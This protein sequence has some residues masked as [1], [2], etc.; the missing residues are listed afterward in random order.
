MPAW[1]TLLVH[2]FLDKNLRNFNSI[3]GELTTSSVPPTIKS[4]IPSGIN[5][6]N[7]QQDRRWM[8]FNLGETLSQVIGVQIKCGLRMPHKNVHL[9][10]DMINLG[11][12]KV[13]MV[14]HSHN[15]GKSLEV[16]LG[17]HLATIVNYPSNDVD[18]YDLEI[19][20]LPN[21]QLRVFVNGE[22]QLFR[23]DFA[24]NMKILVQTINIGIDEEQEQGLPFDYFI[25]YLNV[26]ILKEFDAIAQVLDFL[27]LP[28]C[29]PTIPPQCLK[30]ML[31]RHAKIN[32]MIRDFMQQFSKKHTSNW[33]K[34]DNGPTPI[35]HVA[36]QAHAKARAC[37][38]AFKRASEEHSQE[39]AHSFLNSLEKFLVFLRQ[40]LPAKYEQMLEKIVKTTTPDPECEKFRETYL[41]QLDSASKYMIDLL[42]EAMNI[43]LNTKHYE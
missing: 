43:I 40:H 11:Q 37:G 23:N 10:L 7:I 31:N 35:S 36:K 26:K 17:G 32:R 4:D 2:E 6:L 20:W 39:T 1:K 18:Y 22:L 27:P 9:S 33:D 14:I 5:V 42:E 8:K 30:S 13:N 24:P 34:S 21:G 19:L 3:S 38:I 16:R 12:F 28:K 25:K 29:P 41:N 15:T